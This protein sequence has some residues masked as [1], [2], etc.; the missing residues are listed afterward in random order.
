MIRVFK[1]LPGGLYYPV[2][3]IREAS[4][5]LVNTVDDNKSKYTNLDY[6]RAI[7]AQKTQLMIGRPSTC[8]FISIFKKNLLPN[9]PVRR[10]NIAIA[11]DIFGPGLGFLRRKP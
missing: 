8:S 3:S 6:S 9:C 11:E 7:L 5:L 2:T 10:R 4:T 1:E